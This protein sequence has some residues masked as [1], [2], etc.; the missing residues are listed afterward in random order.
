[1]LTIKPGSDSYTLG[2]GACEVVGDNET[3]QLNQIFAKEDHICC[4]I[5]ATSICQGKKKITIPDSSTATV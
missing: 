2:E 4:K 3:G 5:T 1:M